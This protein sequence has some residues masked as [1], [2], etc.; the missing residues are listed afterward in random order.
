MLRIPAVNKIWKWLSSDSFTAKNTPQLIQN[1]KEMIFAKKL[2]CMLHIRTSTH[3]NI[4]VRVCVFGLKVFLLD[5]FCTFDMIYF[6]EGHAL[7]F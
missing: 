2:A 1:V 7:G 3:I 6:L 4:Y 5:C